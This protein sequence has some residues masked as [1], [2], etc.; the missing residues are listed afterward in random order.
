VEHFQ[1]DA[2]G[3]LIIGISLLTLNISVVQWDWLKVCVFIVAIPFATLIYTSSKSS[4]PAWLF[5]ANE[6]AVS[7]MSLHD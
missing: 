6:R 5:G 7:C 2:F 3:E 4:L 1:V